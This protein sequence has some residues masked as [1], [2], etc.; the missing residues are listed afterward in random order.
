MSRGGEVR[1]SAVLKALIHMRSIPVVPGGKYLFFQ[2]GLA[3]KAAFACGSMV[4][5]VYGVFF[6]HPAGQKEHTKL[7]ADSNE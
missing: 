7:A 2:L 5:Y 1:R 6:F 3:Q 4:L